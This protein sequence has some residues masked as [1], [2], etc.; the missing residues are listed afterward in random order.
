[1]KS[2]RRSA[3][4]ERSAT[5]VADFQETRMDLWNKINPRDRIPIR[6]SKPNLYRDSRVIE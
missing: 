6:Q 1:M 3:A 5:V 4:K 2:R